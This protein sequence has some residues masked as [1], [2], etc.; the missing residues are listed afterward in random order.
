MLF[1]SI[2]TISGLN[3]RDNID[4]M[5]FSDPLGLPFIHRLCNAMHFNHKITLSVSNSDVYGIQLCS[6]MI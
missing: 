6:W 5:T 2:Q 4:N 1:D 3:A